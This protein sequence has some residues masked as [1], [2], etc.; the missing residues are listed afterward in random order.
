[1]PLNLGAS[2][3]S[4]PDRYIRN[5][6]YMRMQHAGTPLLIL[7]GEFDAYPTS[8]RK[9][10]VELDRLGIP[11]QLA[12]YWG[13]G[14]NLETRGNIGDA[15]GRKLAWFKHFLTENRGASKKH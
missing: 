14:H 1:M 4:D 2:P 11:V 9:V 6:P 10:F 8:V 12:Q 7:Y 13:E 15:W 3:L 5:S